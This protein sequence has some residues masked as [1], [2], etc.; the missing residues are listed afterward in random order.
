[1][2]EWIWSQFKKE[3]L[4]QASVITGHTFKAVLVNR[5]GPTNTN[6]PTQHAA[7]PVI[8]DILNANIGGNGTVAVAPTLP[9]DASSFNGGRFDTSDVSTPFAS[10]AAGTGGFASSADGIVIYDSNTGR[11]MAVIEIS[12]V[13]FTGGSVIVTWD[14]ATSMNGQTG[15]IFAL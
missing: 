14:N 1:M 4:Q 5:G 2:A 8:G 9:T 12:S 7:N 10:V 3:C 13:T 15:G 11:L 6:L